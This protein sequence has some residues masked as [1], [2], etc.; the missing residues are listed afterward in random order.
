MV[1]S[2]KFQGWRPVLYGGGL[3]GKTV[4]VIGMGKLGQAFARLLSGFNAKIIYHD[5]V[6]MSPV[7][8]G[9]LGMSR[10][11]LDEVLSQ[12]DVLVLMLPLNPSTLHLVNAETLAKM[13]PGAYL[14]NVGRGSLVDEGAVSRALE[15]GRLAG[16]AT[17]VF[18]MEDDARREHPNSVHPG[19]LAN[20][21]RTLLTPHLG[22]AVDQARLEIELSAARSILEALRG[23][24]PKHAIND[25]GVSR[26]HRE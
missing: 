4:G 12:S 7:Q 25:P 8:E 3:M 15:Q 5:P 23:E 22:T 21:D 20:A 16:Y 10:A 18:E 13:K 14:V 19:L 26:A 9:F 17:D 6:S 2:G 11:T 1:R 24:R